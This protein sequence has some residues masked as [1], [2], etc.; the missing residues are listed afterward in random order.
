METAASLIAQCG[1]RFADRRDSLKRQHPSHN[2]VTIWS[3]EASADGAR[4][5]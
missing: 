3:R 4:I 5:K 2:A 1:S